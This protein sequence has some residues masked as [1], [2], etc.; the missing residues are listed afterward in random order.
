[1]KKLELL[2]IFLFFLAAVLQYNDPD[3]FW[4]VL[5]YGIAGF[6]TLE[7]Y[8]NRIPVL[9]GFFVAVVFC[10]GA[11]SDLNNLWGVYSL[12]GSEQGNEALGLLITGIWIAILAVR[13]RN[14]KVTNSDR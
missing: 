2:F 4:W 8:R 12:F 9:T 5:V 14:G 1:M 11:L 7:A 13:G 3:P 6:L 10:V